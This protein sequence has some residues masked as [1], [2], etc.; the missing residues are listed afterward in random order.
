MSL[1]APLSDIAWLNPA[2]GTRVTDTKQPVAFLPMAGVEADLTIVE[3]TETRA[4]ETVKQGFTSYQ[5]GDILVAKIT[6]C[7]E[8]GK[9]AQVRLKETHGFGSTEFHVIRANPSRVDSRYL[10]HFLRQERVRIA[11]IRRMTGSAGQRRVPKQFFEDLVV[12]L[13]PLDEQRRIAAILDKADALRAKRRRALAK[14]DSLTQSIFLDMFGDPATNPMGWDLIRL[15]GACQLENGRAF[16]PEEWEEEGLP[17][18]RIQNLND[19]SKPYNYSTQVYRDRFKVK[20]GDILF[21]WSGTPGTSFGCFRWHGSDGWL[22][23]HIFNV[24]L[25]GKL[26]S[27]FFM[28]NV[29]SKLNE[30]IGK[31]HGGVGLQHVTK[32]MVDETMLFLPPMPLQTKYSKAVS[33]CKLVR[34][35]AAAVMAKLDLVFTSLQHL[36]FNGQLYQRGQTSWTI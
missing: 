13:P 15:D 1:S 5:T 21:S 23:Q 12:P 31:A 16:K 4:Y 27:E 2:F 32:G 14:L 35:N 10:I 3:P 25:N 6:P 36:A 18:I 9:L 26:D 29:N 24:R 17:I 30:L 22:N 34:A 7:F 11:G 28:E 33:H 8:N 19:P 20:N